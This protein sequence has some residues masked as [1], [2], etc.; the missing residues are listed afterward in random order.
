MKKIFKLL[1]KSIGKE[2]VKFLINEL[3][4]EYRQKRIKEHPSETMFYQTNESDIISHLQK[5]I[6]DGIEKGNIK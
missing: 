3:F 4:D 2:I 1:W 5:F 6:I